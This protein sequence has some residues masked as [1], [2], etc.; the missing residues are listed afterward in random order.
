MKGDGGKIEEKEKWEGWRQQLLYGH[1][2]RPKNFFF[3]PLS[4][5]VWLKSGSPKRFFRCPSIGRGDAYQLY[6]QCAKP[7]VGKPCENQGR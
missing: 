6:Q 2:L 1:S 7:Q 3:F 5:G 4:R